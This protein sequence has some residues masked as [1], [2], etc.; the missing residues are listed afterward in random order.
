MTS[1]I[2]LTLYRLQNNS[3]ARERAFE[4]LVSRNVYTAAQKPDYLT[5][6][7]TAPTFASVPA[8][9]P[10]GTQPAIQRTPAQ[11]VIA[12]AGQDIA[13]S[14]ANASSAGK[15]A[16]V[17]ALLAATALF[18]NNSTESIKGTEPHAVARTNDYEQKNQRWRNTHHGQ[19]APWYKPQDAVDQ[20]V[21]DEREDG[22]ENTGG[23]AGL[24][25]LAAGALG[26]AAI[27]R[28]K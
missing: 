11:H 8:G 6:L 2:E 13:S 14:H 20:E 25:A 1:Q 23:L 3:G 12:D 19:N 16:I 26:I 10:A 22:K 4:E 5:H 27:W 7:Y 18:Y 24:I 9:A 17:A 28:K 21:S 15:V